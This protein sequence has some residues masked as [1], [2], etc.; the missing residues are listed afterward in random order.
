MTVRFRY[1]TLLLLAFSFK[2]L[3]THNRAGE[4]TYE[5]IDKL[6][7]KVTIT[8]VTNTKP[9]SDGMTPADRE[10]LIIN[11]GDG[12]YSELPRS[13]KIDLPD[14]YR[15]NQYIGYHQYAG[16]G[17][18]NIVVEDPNRNEGVE[19][20]PN[21]VNVVFSIKTLL[22]IEP[23]LGHNS[24]PVLTN[25][26]V[27][28]AAVG[29]LFIHNPAAFDP[30]GD[31]L[32][33]EMTICT[34]LDGLPIQGYTLPPS[35]HKPIYID[36]VLG[37]LVWDAPTAAGIYNVAF[38]IKEWRKGVKIGQITRDMQIEVF[39]SE[40]KPPF[41]DSV[42]PVCVIAGDTVNL[43]I[44]AKDSIS[45]NITITASGGIFE[46]HPKPQ[47]TNTQAIGEVNAH[48][49]WVTTDSAV[50]EQPYQVV[51]KAQDDNAQVNLTHQRMVEITV[52]GA[53]VK[54]VRL[55]PSSNSILIEW[56]KYKAR[57][58]TGF[59]IYRSTQ[60]TGYIPDTCEKGVPSGMG[61]LLIATL[62]DSVA[63]SFLDNNN[64]KGL[65]QGYTYC[66]LVTA[67]YPDV[68]SRASEEVCT[69]LTRG[70][71]IITNVSVEKNDAVTGEIFIGWSKPS[72]LDSIKYP[73][74]YQYLIRRADG[75]WGTNYTTVGTLNSLDDTVFTDKNINT[76]NTGYN[77]RV[78]IHNSNG[79]TEQPMTAST[80]YPKPD[81]SNKAIKLTFVKNVP[82]SNYQ[83][84]VYRQRSDASAFDSIGYTD[85]EWFTDT[86]LVNL[87]NYCYRV[88]STGKYDLPGIKKPLINK[89]HQVCSEPVDT[90]PP[91]A[92][93][94]NLNGNCENFINQLTWEPAQS[95]EP[96][97]AYYIYFGETVDEM[98]VIDTIDGNSPLE[99]IHDAKETP[100]GC[101]AVTAIDSTGNESA[102]SNL[103][104]TDQCPYYELPNVFS[105]NS[106]KIND[107]FIP[108]TPKT[109]IEKYVEKIDLKIYSRWGNVVF[110]TTDKFI[111]WDGK[112]KQTNKMV[113]TGVYYYVCNVWE[114]RISGTEQRYLVGFVHVFTNQK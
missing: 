105:P 9:T 73:G 28:K 64:K 45:E 19:N 107:L 50:R 75:I 57:H 49:Q 111:N 92:G 93:T 101:Y 84:I 79:L 68:E 83:Y 8:T 110:E 72:E 47:L 3:A 35:S 43:N 55:S 2:C 69:Q 20:I 30:D 86:N 59:K 54:N 56:D 58:H 13:V 66:Y 99:F 77:Y 52:I 112:S 98:A 90:I 25:L 76:L 61:Y 109:V 82:W 7:Y 1:I 48:F 74:P 26:P 38:L 87:N 39:D 33:Y 95:D 81:G 24:T 27:D 60:K 11:W 104:C 16:P 51:F 36:S 23:Q 21:S 96:V 18:F 12:T 85:D 46:F 10:S 108:I 44:H 6:I 4:I 62:T 80:L 106:D 31:S 22:V 14:Y 103:V 67:T 114:K 29:K 91:I 42:P 41:I 34:G 100:S 113:S 78:E 71:P 89:S 53:P 37:N 32:S 70:I 65:N 102:L 15:K 40:N 5:Q 88:T 94:I 97:F 63:V 17:S